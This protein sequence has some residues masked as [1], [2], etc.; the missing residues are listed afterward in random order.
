MPEQDD[1]LDR[2][3]RW[4]L[5]QVRERL[6]N[7]G[8]KTASLDGRV[9][10]ARAMNREQTWFYTNPDAPVWDVDLARFNEMVGRREQRIPV[11][12]ILGEREFW[13]RPFFVSSDVL[14]PRPDSETLIE[15]VLEHVSDRK[16]PLRILDLGTG[17]GCLLLTLLAELSEATGTGVDVSEAALSVAKRNAEQFGYED[18]VSWVRGE[19]E[20][21][22]DCTFDVVISNPPYIETSDLANLEP[23]VVTY[24]PRLALDGGTD[25]LDAYRRILTHVGD[26]MEDGAAAF[27]EIGYGQAEEVSQ[28]ARDK[29]FERHGILYDLSDTARVLSFIRAGFV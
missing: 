16:K 4:V 19:W 6:Q 25:G 29:G 17:S 24:E 12:H 26:V 22:L 14:T 20:V 7:A 21:G 10:L 15:A 1:S 23:E 11:S 18:R 3:V 8:I 13:S 9:L 2:S 28:I 27:F 5:A